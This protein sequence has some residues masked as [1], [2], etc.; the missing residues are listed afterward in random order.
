MCSRPFLCVACF[1]GVVGCTSG[2]AK[3]RSD[4]WLRVASDS[5]YDIAIDTTR[6]TNHYGRDYVVWYWTEHAVSHLYKGQPFNREI[7]QGMLQCHNLS[8][9]IVSVDMSL[10]GGRLISHQNTTNGELGQQP[11]RHVEDGTIEAVVAKAT[12]DLVRGYAVS[13]R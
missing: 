7:V 2:P 9:K 4:H 12:C 8:F 1:I 10:G 3:D 5:S 6:I 11:W 13:R